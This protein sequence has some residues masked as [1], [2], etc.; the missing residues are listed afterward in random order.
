MCYYVHMQRSRYS[1]A[2]YRLAA[3]HHG[4]FTTSEAVAAGVPAG[5]VVMMARRG[6]LERISQGVYRLGQY[7]ISPLGQYFEA[8]LWPQRGTMGV[9]SHDSALAFHQLSDVSPSRV[10]ITLPRSYRARRAV[11]AYLVLHHAD[12]APGDTEVIEGVPVTSVAR[13]LRDC[14]GLGPQVLR[15]A[16][17][18]ARATGRIS[19]A[20]ADAIAAL[21][22]S[23]R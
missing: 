10:H 14:A 13:T 6:T 11:P 19:A 16:L 20:E 5:A 8:V 18:D 21:V 9:L 22:A 15:Q 2:I 4:Y 1:E 23:G 17:S 3:A 12:L 7:P